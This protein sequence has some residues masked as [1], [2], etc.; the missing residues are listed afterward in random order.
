MCVH[1]TDFKHASESTG[2]GA[3]EVTPRYTQITPHQ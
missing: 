3:I 2:Q 1:V